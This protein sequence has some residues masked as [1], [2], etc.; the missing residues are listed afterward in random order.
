MKGLTWALAA[1][2]SCYQTTHPT[3]RS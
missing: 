1:K 2:L 3:K